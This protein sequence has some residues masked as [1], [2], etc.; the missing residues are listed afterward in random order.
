M[1]GKNWQKIALISGTLVA[2]LLT[3]PTTVPAGS[4]Y[5]FNDCGTSTYFKWTGCAG[6]KAEKKQVTNVFAEIFGWLSMG[7][8]VAAVGGMVYGGYLYM[9]SRGNKSQTEKAMSVIRSVVI[10]LV[11]Y[12]GMYTLLNFIVPGGLFVTQ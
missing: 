12:Y 11:L 7:V 6:G 4:V 5:A 10:A 3:V 1:F 2:V 8:F 9:T